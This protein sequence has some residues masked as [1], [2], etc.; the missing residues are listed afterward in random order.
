MMRSGHAGSYLYWSERR[1]AE[2]ASDNG[3][4]L[5]GQPNW[6]LK[7]ALQGIGVEV[8]NGNRGDLTRREKAGK[9]EKH[10]GAQAASALDKPPPARFAKGA[11]QIHIARFLGGPERDKGAMFHIRTTSSAG[12]HID[13]VLFG[14]MDNFPGRILRPA[15]APEAGWFSSAWHAV[16][17][18]LESR[19]TRNTSQWDDPEQLSVEALNIALNQG[20]TG[21]EE[22]HEDRPWTR[23]YTLAHTDDSEWFTQIY[24]DV[25]LT[26]SRWHLS[27]NMLGAQRII[28]GAPVWIRTASPTSLIRYARLPDRPAGGTRRRR[29]PF[30]R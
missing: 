20:S 2:V 5:D 21:T 27:G 24:T 19:G 18:L 23:G 22:E 3:I 26:E 28:V 1:V 7:A 15:D 13:L 9:I 12:Q 30:L 29:L 8:G 4:K 17:E 10:I 16:A 6:T 25:L 14:S 11:G